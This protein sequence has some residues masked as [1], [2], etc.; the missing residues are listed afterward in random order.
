MRIAPV[1]R[2]AADGRLTLSCEVSHKDGTVPDLLW[3]RVH[4]R[5]E[6]YLTDVMDPFLLAALFV[7]MR[8]GE[9]LH[10]EGPV[11]AQLLENLEEFQA[12]WVQWRPEKYT[13]V[14]LTADRE[15]PNRDRSAGRSALQTFSGGVDSAYTTIRH[16]KKA[17]GRGSYELTGAV[18]VHGFDIPLEEVEAYD[19]LYTRSIPLLQGVGVELLPVTT[20]FR[21]LWHSDLRYWEDAF[22]TGMASVL[23]LF[24]GRFEHGIVASSEP[25]GS[26]VLPWG[27]NPMTD[28]MM[29][30]G[31]MRIHHDAAGVERSDK[32]AALA[33]LWPNGADNLRVC[34]Q[35][36]HKDRNCCRCEKCIRTILN[37][38]VSGS[39]LPASFP[40]DVTPDQI[41]SLR[42]LS[43]AHVNPLRQILVTARRRGLT[44]E[45]VTAL[46][47]CIT[48]NEDEIAR[49][50]TYEGGF[51]QLALTG[52]EA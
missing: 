36:E 16:V 32:V 34:W 45:W 1:R 2:S 11:T 50:I 49:G 27:S 28:W 14:R 46:A 29:S 13:A 51:P 18:M 8:K 35:G 19:T 31:R 44:D 24:S 7:A 3:Y 39:P 10:V 30:G 47:D 21:K 15:V 48:A 26:L 52:D 41:M 37:F 4:S 42:G 33:K 20:N 22:A 38:K 23:T 25:Y 43:E 12:A 40:L 9:D 5:H 6:E 17:A